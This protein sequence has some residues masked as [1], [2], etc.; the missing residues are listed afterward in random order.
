MTDSASPPWTPSPFLRWSTAVHLACLGAALVRPGTRPWATRIVA[1]NQLLI[2]TAGLWPR[3][4][5]L[6]P[7]L[8]RLPPSPTPR[9]ALTFDDGPDPAVTPAVLELLGERDIRASFFLVGQRALAHPELVHSLVERG[10]RVENHTFHHSHRFAF[11]GPQGLGLE[12]QRAQDVLT[13]LTGRAPTHFR[14]PAGMRNPF[15][16]PVLHRLG[17]RLVSW[18]RRGFDGVDRDPDAVV[19]RLIHHLGDGDI[20]LLHD[21][22]GPRTHSGVPVILE[23]LPRVLDALDAQGLTTT[24]L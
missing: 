14:A 18:T 10:H 23:T 8:T 22:H 13:E 15:V 9:V 11:H 20:L 3:S 2:S 4:Q 19:R 1:A 12:I 16:D 17:L 24:L 7:N 21:A 6:G 5:L